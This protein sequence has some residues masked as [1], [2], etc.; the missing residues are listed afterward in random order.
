MLI[1]NTPPRRERERGDM[2][3][4]ADLKRLKVGDRLTMISAHYPGRLLGTT[5]AIAKM[6]S[7]S[8]MFEGGSWLYFPKAKDFKGT[9]DG[10]EIWENVTVHRDPNPDKDTF[11][12]VCML[13]YRVEK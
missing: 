9:P 10:F 11:S 8:L 5:R 13:A 3:T 7:N 6:Q 2:K 12:Y 4:L 1:V